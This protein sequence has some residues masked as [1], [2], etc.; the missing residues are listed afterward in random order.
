MKTL[1]A[2]LLMMFIA[3]VFSKP[4]RLHKRS[5]SSDSEGSEENDS[6]GGINEDSQSVENSDQSNDSSEEV[7]LN[8]IS[9]I[10]TTR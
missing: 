2:M 4:S 6:R 5:D 3:S 9:P 10:R 1:H 7:V 8:T